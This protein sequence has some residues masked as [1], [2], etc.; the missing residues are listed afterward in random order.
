LKITL[1]VFFFFLTFL[2]KMISDA[3]LN[4]WARGRNVGV[5]GVEGKVP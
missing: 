2:R 5:G 4:P 3:A 1:L